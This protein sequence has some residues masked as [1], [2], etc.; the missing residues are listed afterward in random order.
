VTLK[1][2]H[3]IF[4]SSILLLAIGF[5][6]SAN[7]VFCKTEPSSQATTLCREGISS[8]NR[9]N[10]EV[11]IKQF[12]DA[13]NI[14][15][16]YGTAVGYLS[17]A[18]NR[19]GAR[20]D[21]NPVAGLREF[22]TALFYDDKNQKA[23]GN[24]KLMIRLLG[25][26]PDNADDRLK[27]A[28]EAI[29]EKDYIGAV[30]E[31][32][33]ALALK[34]DPDIRKKLNDASKLAGPRPTI[35]HDPDLKKYMT[36]VQRKVKS[37]WRPPRSFLSQRSTVIFQVNSAGEASMLRLITPS[38]FD[39]FDK[40]ALE[41]VRRA[42]PFEPIPANTSDQANVL[43][44]FDY[45]A[46]INNYNPLTRTPVSLSAQDIQ[47]K[48]Q[49]LEEPS[50]KSDVAYWETTPKHADEFIGALLHLASYYI[51]N[52]RNKEAEPLLIQSEKM[53]DDANPTYNLPDTLNDLAQLY[54]NE[55]QYEL[56]EQLL[57]R[58][59]K[60]CENKP[61]LGLFK[62]SRA[63]TL[64]AQLKIQTNHAELAKDIFNRVEDLI[65][66]QRRSIEDYD[67]LIDL[68]SSSAINYFLRGKLYFDHSD[69]NHATKD[70]DRAIELNP[71]YAYAFALRARCEN[72]L[73]NDDDALKDISKSKDIDPTFSYAYQTSAAIHSRFKQWD[74]AIIDLDKAISL[75]PLSAENFQA[76]GNAYKESNNYQQALKDF[77]QSLVFQPQNASL[78]RSRGQVYSLLKQYQQALNDFEA[79]ARLKPDE[80]I[81]YSFLGLAY[82]KTKD[83]EKAVEKL[84]QCISINTTQENAHLNRGFALGRLGQF[85]RAVEDFNEAIKQDPNSVLN[86]CDRSWAQYCLQ[87]YESAYEEGDKAI[88]L[89]QHSA[90]A[91]FN[92]G[93]A[94]LKLQNYDSALDDLNRAI[95]IEPNLLNGKAFYYRAKTY[96]KLS[97]PDLAEEDLAKAKF[98]GMELS[99][100]E[101]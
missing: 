33:S 93:R 55:K 5:N 97:K 82:I 27:L 8:V 17:Y 58:S 12:E 90:C 61:E 1:H 25:K 80:A 92:R 46:L 13:L 16:E 54:C 32:E 89:D 24:S 14:R 31:L 20:L 99:K 35:I 52:G 68:D 71:Q 69:W 67:K 47:K 19:E 83:W 51:R 50:L 66:K 18:H 29:L 75:N 30:I 7:P 101:E 21:S 4:P 2:K 76:R 94:S 22:C 64:Y 10:F 44:T 72:Q 96:Q 62:L 34:E 11:G 48:I 49:D 74:L 42:A 95:A 78:Y 15:P 43:F 98:L 65:H 86:Y 26:N 87:K 88:S 56:A 100:Q 45:N 6:F 79:A 39:E 38:G 85:D 37:T 59:I 70:F 40:L 63:L 3:R 73:K 36:D 91:F 77:D 23:L 9:G 41:T 81:N 57:N 53:Q 28:E 60:L 84:D